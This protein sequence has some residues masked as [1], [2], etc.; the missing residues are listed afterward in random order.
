MPLNL[1]TSPALNGLVD[2]IRLRLL[3]TRL[4]IF[5]SEDIPNSF[6][7]LIRPGERIIFKPR[8]IPVIPILQR[9]EALP[10]IPQLL[11]IRKIQRVQ[12][13]PIHNCLISENKGET[14]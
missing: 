5:R 1:S 6:E 4:S 2:N 12:H 7:L 11:G 13:I 8:N 9:H 10:K 3:K 14:Y